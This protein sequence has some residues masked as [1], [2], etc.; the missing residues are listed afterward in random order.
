MITSYINL[1]MDFTAHPFESLMFLDAYYFRHGVIKIHSILLQHSITP[2]ALL[3]TRTISRVYSGQLW[4]PLLNPLPQMYHKLPRWCKRLYLISNSSRASWT[5]LCSPQLSRAQSH[6]HF[7]IQSPNHCCIPILRH[8]IIDSTCC[9]LA[10]AL[11]NSVS[12]ES[13]SFR[14]LDSHRILSDA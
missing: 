14:R 13:L 10:E 4:Q 2:T 1:R 12:L 8:T 6:S 9:N 11:P 5:F 7:Q 3:T